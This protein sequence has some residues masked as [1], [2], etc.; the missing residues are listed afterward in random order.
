MSFSVTILG[1]GS[2]LPTAK[3]HHSAHV[4]N[5]HE[6]FYLVDCGEGTQR[7]LMLAGINPLKINAIFIS[8]LHGD[9][10]Y[11]VFP[12][13]STMNMMGRGRALKIFAPRPFDELLAHHKRYFDTELCYDIEF[14]EVDTRR[15]EVIFE[16]NTMEVLTI[17]L[18]H[19]I[20]CAG[21]LFR[22]KAPQRNIHPQM[23]ERYGLSI[24]QRV[25]AKRGE[26]I[27][28][29]DNQIIANEQ[30]TYI[31]YTPASYAYLSDTNYS[32]KAAQL[33]KGVD[34]LYHEATFADADRKF[35]KQTGHSTTL[36]AARVAELAGA[37]RLLIGHFS[38]RYKDESVLLAQTQGHFAESS[39]AEEL[40]CYKIR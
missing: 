6:Q 23:I 25:A 12:L 8:H 9:H 2:A 14:C 39:I 38:P 22:E 31:P 10:I 40:H 15:H 5:V 37:K 1:S 20:A 13:I 27:L 34:L 19:K 4:L 3:K 33:V 18:R 35:A 30:L 7:Q 16:S 28:L 36:Q 11:G 26:D 32:A 17:P 21:Y 29:D 24:A